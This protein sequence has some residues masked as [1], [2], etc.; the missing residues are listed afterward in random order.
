MVSS[1]CLDFTPHAQISFK[2]ADYKFR[3]VNATGGPKSVGLRAV[4]KMTVVG[5]P[6]LPANLYFRVDNFFVPGWN[7]KNYL[8]MRLQNVC[9]KNSK[10]KRDG[11]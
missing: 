3:R 1:H 7:R 2:R 9:M 10:S 6:R 8:K 5:T 4:P 11:P